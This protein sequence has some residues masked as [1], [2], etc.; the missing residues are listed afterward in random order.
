MKIQITRNWWMFTLNG[1]LAI[2]YAIFALFV[3]TD[4]LVVLAKYSGLFILIAGIFMLIMAIYRIRKQVPYGIALSQALITI[5]LGSLIL[6]YTQ[7]TISFF[8]MLLGIWALLLGVMLLVILVNLSGE[9]PNKNMLLVNALVSL[10]VGVIL[11]INPFEVATALVILSGVLSL[12]FGIILLWF[13]VQL[14]NLGKNIS[15]PDSL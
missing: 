5:I 8:V 13:S 3:P 12:G 15:E 2:F 11:L 14:R 4:T 7:Q 1:L 6:I 10:L 9:L